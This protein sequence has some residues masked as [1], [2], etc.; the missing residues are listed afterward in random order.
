ME[1]DLFITL[2]NTAYQGPP[3]L[4]KSAGTFLS[5]QVYELRWHDRIKDISAKTGEPEWSGQVISVDGCLKLF[6]ANTGKLGKSLG[7]FSISQR[8]VVLPSSQE[9]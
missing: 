3:L 6:N 2:C 7:P 1:F 5:H 4:A 9:E 8:V